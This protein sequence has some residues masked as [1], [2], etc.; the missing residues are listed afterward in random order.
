MR[1][2]EESDFSNNKTRSIMGKFLLISSIVLTALGGFVANTGDTQAIVILIGSIFLVLGVYVLFPI[3]LSWILKL[4][5]PMM[6]KYL[7]GIHLLLLN[8]IPQVR[9]IH[10]LS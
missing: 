7:E 8:L 6:K 5:L 2:N 4:C 10:L 3:Y 9:K 1:E